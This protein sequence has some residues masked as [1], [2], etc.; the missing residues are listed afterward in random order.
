MQK[1]VLVIQ[2]ETTLI[3][4]TFCASPKQN[5]NMD[6]IL[7]L[8]PLFVNSRNPVCNY[9][10]SETDFFSESSY[11]Q[12]RSNSVKK[13]D[14][15]WVVFFALFQTVKVSVQKRRERSRACNFPI[16]CDVS[17]R[18]HIISTYSWHYIHR[19]TWISYRTIC[20]RTAYHQ[21]TRIHAG[22]FTWKAS[23]RST[24]QKFHAYY[25]TA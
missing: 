21:H 3:C 8:Q 18:C 13:A 12:S 24:I 25:G 17:D 19:S 9:H 5:R 6:Y 11:N 14:C 16:T 7:H 22:T 10:I 15:C 23:S 1:P 4:P 2:Q 20:T